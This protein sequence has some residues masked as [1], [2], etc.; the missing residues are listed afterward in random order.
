[1]KKMPQELFVPVGQIIKTTGANPRT[2]GTFVPV[3]IQLKYALLYRV[4]TWTEQFL[5]IRHQTSVRGKPQ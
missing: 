4:S 2:T 3:V 5:V 1:M